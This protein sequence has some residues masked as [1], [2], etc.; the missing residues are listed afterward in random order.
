MSRPREPLTFFVDRDLGPQFFDLLAVDGRFSVEFH[1][2]HFNDPTTD[3]S[4][5]LPFVAEKDWIAVT[6][7]KKIRAHHRPIIADYRVKV[8]IAVGSRTVADHAHNFL[9]TFPRIERFVRDRPGPYT[10]KL[11]HPAPAELKRF[12]PK[13]RIE[14]WG[15]W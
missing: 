6:H 12:K 8:V 15:E 11:Y 2:K 5:W 3:D 14:L 10:A 7:D 9:T 1:D 13:G 4:Q